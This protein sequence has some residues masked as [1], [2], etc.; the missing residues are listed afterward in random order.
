MIQCVPLSSFQKHTLFLHYADDIDKYLGLPKS[1]DGGTL[2]PQAEV[3]K[4]FFFYQSIERLS[5]YSSM[6]FDHYSTTI[7]I[8]K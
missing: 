4:R 7:I 2:F 5:L 1:S 8:V 3:E 6:L